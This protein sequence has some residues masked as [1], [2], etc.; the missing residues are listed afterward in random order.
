VDTKSLSGVQIKDAD[1]GLV[2]AVFATL[3]TIDSDGDVTMPGAFGEGAPVAISSYGHTSWSG[4]LPVGKGTIHTVGDQAI[5]DGQFFM[6]TTAGR[7]TF[8]VVKQLGGQQEWSYGYEPTE[9]SYGEQD[10][11][12]VRFLKQLQVFEVSPVLRGAGVGTRLLT[13][14]SAALEPGM[15]VMDVT[16]S[17]GVTVTTVAT[18]NSV[19]GPAL[20][21]RKQGTVVIAPHQTAIDTGPWDFIA[22]KA[23][24]DDE[25]PSA[26]RSM[27]AWC[28][29][30]ADPER[31]SSYRLVHHQGPG[32]AANLRA[33][34]AGVAALNGSD[35]ACV[36]EVE[37]K[38]AYEH[39]A[40]HMRDADMDPPEFGAGPAS[41]LKFFDH[42][43][44]VLA[45]V[46]SF[47][48]RASEVMALR[49]TKGKGFSPGSADLLSWIQDETVRLKTLL[50]PP[51]PVEEPLRDD[52]L[53]TLMA[54]QAIVQNL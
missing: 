6:N 20:E 47:V 45:A 7:D 13:A 1:Q 36:P 14:K 9:F 49:A 48:D 24:P 27:H 23:L 30:D 18:G 37:R 50:T 53:S 29:P 31:K 15:T 8:E 33:V 43:A 17:P 32:Q 42:G 16:N 51:P 28:D 46:S 22:V 3:G 54:A 5:L 40:A 25:R 21:E 41:G 19:P 52:E 38:A 2:T 44:V 34:V 11:Q 4:I 26:L 39:L 35:G 10:G 12:S